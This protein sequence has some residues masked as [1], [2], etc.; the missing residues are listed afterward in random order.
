MCHLDTDHGCG[1]TGRVA[2]SSDQPALR[3]AATLPVGHPQEPLFDVI[4]AFRPPEIAPNRAV[5]VELTNAH[6]DGSFSDVLRRLLEG[7]WHA[8]RWLMERGSPPNGISNLPGAQREPLQRPERP[9]LCGFDY[10]DQ[11]PSGEAVG[12]V[13]LM[14]RP[15]PD[16][17]E[18]RFVD[19][20][21]TRENILRGWNPGWAADCRSAAGRV[22]VEERIGG[23]EVN[24]ID[25]LIHLTDSRGRAFALAASNALKFGLPLGFS[26][27]S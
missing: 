21:S 25:A 27:V 12:G 1:L 17:S 24:L 5:E 8:R 6:G 14:C 23:L 7:T 11:A 2:F 18:N 22:L 26:S 13:L 15:L 19:W 20:M 16:T 10:I 9:F 3:I 4:T